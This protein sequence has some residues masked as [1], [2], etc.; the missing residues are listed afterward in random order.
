MVQYRT[1]WTLP[2]GGVAPGEQPDE[3]ALRELEEETGLRGHV[4]RLLFSE[5]T[6]AGHPC[7]CFLV[8][9]DSTQEATLGFD[10]ELPPDG[11]Y[12]HDVRWFPLAEKADDRQV[13]Q[14]I[15][16]LAGEQ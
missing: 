12:L 10:P 16:A 5:P 6:T 3:A 8:E 13:S 15:R 14:V 7:H 11:Q 2:G 4:V 1:W 9:V